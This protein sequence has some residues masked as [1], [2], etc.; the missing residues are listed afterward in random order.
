MAPT[1]LYIG[2]GDTAATIPDNEILASHL[3]NL[4][5]FKVLDYNGW[6]HTDFFAGIDAHELVYGPIIDL[7]DSVK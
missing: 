4:L 7:M 6:T 5:A 2:D 3:P 1:A